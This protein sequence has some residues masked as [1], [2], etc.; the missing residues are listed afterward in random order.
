MKKLAFAALFVILM[1]LVAVGCAKT[2]IVSGTV[3]GN[4]GKPVSGASVSLGNLSATTDA[5]GR[6]SFENVKSGDYVLAV[7]A[8]GA[9]PASE[10]LAVSEGGT[11]KNVT[12]IFNSLEMVKRAGVM[13]FGSDTTYAPFESIDTQTNTAVGFDV[14]LASLLAS[15]IGVK[16]QIISTDFGGI[17]PALQTGKFD[18]IISS[19]T[20]TEARRA[21]IDFSEPYYN[22]GQ[23]LAVQSKNNLISKPQDLVGKTVGVQIGTTG[24]EAAKGIKGA[25]VKSYPDIQLALADLETG[26]IDAVINDLPVSAFYAKGHPGVK[27][28]GSL[29]TTEQYG[30]AFR[31]DETE[32]RDAID[33]ALAQIRADGEYDKLYEQWFG[34]KPQ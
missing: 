4:D 34:T 15:K 3:F 1:L 29:F 22:S 20:I 17:I 13:T 9:A 25:T 12:L 26:R 6:F 19:M 8:Q 11:T 14:D 33:A 27:L 31:K 32:L 23:I 24:E 10:K 5:N 7:S 18:A 30:I 16:A 28:V 21:E 2:G